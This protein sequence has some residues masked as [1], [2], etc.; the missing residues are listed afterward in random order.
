MEEALN[1][2]GEAAL[3]FYV[4]LLQSLSKIV[5][6]EHIPRQIVQAPVVPMF[7]SECA[8]FEIA[9]IP[10]G[11][12]AGEVIGSVP[13]PYLEWLDSQPDFRSLLRRYLASKQVQRQ[14][15]VDED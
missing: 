14:M 4:T 8:H 2:Q 12:Y 1:H 3:R 10:F 5:P 7:P 13:L 15:V 6:E 11:Q 9:H